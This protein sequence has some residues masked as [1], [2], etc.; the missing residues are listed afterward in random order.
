MQPLPRGVNFVELEQTFDSWLGFRFWFCRP[1]GQNVMKVQLFVDFAGM[2][3]CFFGEEGIVVGV[4]ET[5]VGSLSK[6]IVFGIFKSS[7]P[8]FSLGFW[9]CRSDTKGPHQ[10]RWHHL[11]VNKGC[12]GVGCRSPRKTGRRSARPHRPARWPRRSP[13]G[14]RVRRDFSRCGTLG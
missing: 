4:R 1:P 9:F 2:C 14:Y 7:F 11:R 8:G 13:S 6:K 10:G 3:G 12:R 5:F